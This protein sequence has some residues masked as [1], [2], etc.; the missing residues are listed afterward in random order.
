MKIKF[1][2]MAGD[3]VGSPTIS[4]PASEIAGI[5]NVAALK[6]YLYKTYPRLGELSSMAIAVNKSYANEDTS[7]DSMDEIALIPPVS[8]G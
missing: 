5:N 4:L 1:F 3:I 6:A 7:L 2:G 8:G